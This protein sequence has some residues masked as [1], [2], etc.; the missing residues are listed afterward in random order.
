MCIVLF[1]KNTKLNLAYI[2]QEKNCFIVMTDLTAIYI[3]QWNV[4]FF[5]ARS[6]SQIKQ[7]TNFALQMI[8]MQANWIISFLRDDKPSTERKWKRNKKDS[9]PSLLLL[10]IQSCHIVLARVHLQGSYLVGPIRQGSKVIYPFHGAFLLDKFSEL[11]N[12]YEIFCSTFIFIRRRE[13]LIQR[14]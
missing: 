8:C 2:F 4:K 6:L 14:I 3:L 1:R 13:I 11:V 10:G 9:K 12:I 7:I 5:A